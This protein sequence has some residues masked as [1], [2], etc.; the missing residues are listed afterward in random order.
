[1]SSINLFHLYHLDGNMRAVTPEIKMQGKK[2]K[3]EI[4]HPKVKEYVEGRYKRG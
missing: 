3:G 4:W 1:M 2:E